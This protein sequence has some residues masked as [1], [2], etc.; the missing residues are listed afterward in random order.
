MKWNEISGA[1]QIVAEGCQ[2][3]IDSNY[4]K[5]LCKGWQPFRNGPTIRDAPEISLIN[6]RMMYIV[7]CLLLILSLRVPTFIDSKIFKDTL[8]RLATLQ[9]WSD[10]YIYTFFKNLKIKQIIQIIRCLF[11]LLLRRC[12]RIRDAP[13][14]Y[15]CLFIVYLI[16]NPLYI[17][18][19]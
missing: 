14:L 12:S 2:P 16:N 13:D 8:Q 1:S 7:A 19:T 17:F 15:C 18:V 5:T 10:N 6:L 9:E 3:S 11:F 4:L